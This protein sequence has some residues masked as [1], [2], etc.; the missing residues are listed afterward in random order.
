V[1]IGLLDIVSAEGPM[2]AHRAYRLYSLAADDQRVGPEMRRRFEAA[3]RRAL[4]TAAL[5]QRDHEGVPTDE[6]TLYLPGKPAV[7]VR[8]LGPRSLLEVPRSE[9]AE[10]ITYLHMER[11]PADV[12]KRS[13]L[14]TYGL[15]RLT[16]KTSQY[17]DECLDF[18][19]PQ[20]TTT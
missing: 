12:V 10:L 6:T 16:L 13:V 18:F 9:V 11:V 8:A 15:L 17:L 20:S 3:T 2:H 4:R 19:S 14:N 5:K 7:L 1:A